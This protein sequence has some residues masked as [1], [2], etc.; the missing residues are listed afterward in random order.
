MPARDCNFNG[1]VIVS[2][3]AESAEVARLVMIDAEELVRTVFSGLSALV[4]E[5]VQ[6]AGDAILVRARTRDEPAAL[7]VPKTSSA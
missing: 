1:S 4:I 6:D 5:D 7:C 2:V 3:V